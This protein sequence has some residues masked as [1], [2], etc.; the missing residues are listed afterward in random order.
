IDEFF[1]Y[2]IN[3]TVHNQGNK[4]MPSG[5]KPKEAYTN[6]EHYGSQFMGIPVTDPKVIPVLR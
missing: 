3:H 4:L 5:I 2:W 6:P 1:D